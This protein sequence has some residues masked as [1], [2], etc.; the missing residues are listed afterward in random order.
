MPVGATATGN[1]FPVGNEGAPGGKP[2]SIHNLDSEECPMPQV[3]IT[4]IVVPA[5]FT[6]YQVENSTFSTA[7][8]QSGVALRNGEMSA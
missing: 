8:F 4:D 3:Q 7:L 5:E 2:E 6:A 1:T